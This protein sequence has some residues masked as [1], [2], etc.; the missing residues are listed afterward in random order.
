MHAYRGPVSLTEKFVNLTL[1]GV[2]GDGSFCG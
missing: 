1:K 2:E